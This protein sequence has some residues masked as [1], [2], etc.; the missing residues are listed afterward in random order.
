[1][2]LVATL[3]EFKSWLNYTG[4]ADD[5]E[6]TMVLTAASDWVE[7]AIG[8][9]LGSTS[10]TESVKVEYTAAFPR[11]RPLISVTSI[12]NE[13]TGVVL[14]ASTYTVDTGLSEIRAKSYSFCPGRYTIVYSAGLSAIPTRVKLAGLE[15]ARHLWLIQ[16]GSAG[17]GYPSDELAQTPM[18]FAIP[19]RAQELLAPDRQ[20]LVA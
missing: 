11:K 3:A 13:E 20:V 8:G 14:D 12:T 16:N 15:V 9:P 19:R 6:L 7:Y 18:G 4:T 10:Y 1:M 17:R 2:T 5:T